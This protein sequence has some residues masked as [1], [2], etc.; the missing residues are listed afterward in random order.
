MFNTTEPGFAV[1]WS[2]DAEAPLRDRRHRL[3]LSLASQLVA[4]GFLLPTTGFNTPAC[5]RQRTKSRVFVDRHVIGR[6]IYMLR[7]STVPLV[8]IETHQSLDVDEEARWC[9]ERTLAAFARAVAWGSSRRWGANPLRR[10]AIPHRCCSAPQVRERPGVHIVA[11]P[12]GRCGG[13]HAV[14]LPAGVRE[15]DRRARR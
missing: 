1:L 13:D 9:E 6:R 2:D 3:A 10:S 8:I 11:G 12:A 5:R 4:A 14:E 7:Q 15:P